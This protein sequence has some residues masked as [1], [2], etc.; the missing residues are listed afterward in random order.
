MVQHT[1]VGLIVQV[2]EVFLPVRWKSGWVHRVTVVLRCDVALTSSQVESWNVVGTV[3]VLELDSLRTDCETKQLMTET[4]SK[5][6]DLGRFHQAG[7]VVDGLLAMGWVTRAIGDEYT[8]KVVSNLVDWVVVWEASDGG[9]TADDTAKD[10]LLHT[11]INQ[12]NVEITNIGADM[13]WSFGRDSL[14]QV[15]G[16]R[17]NVCLVLIGI[18][19]LTDSDTAQ[20][21]ALLSEECDNVPGV[22]T[23]D[24][25]HTLPGAPLRQTLNGGPVTVLGCVICNHN[26]RRLDVGRLEVSEQTVLVTGGGGNS[27]VANQWLCE[28]K[29]LSTV[30]GIGHGLWVSD[31]G[32]CEDGLSRDVPVGSERFSCVGFSILAP[33]GFAIDHL[34]ALLTLMVKVARS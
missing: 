10:V 34:F 3:T 31:K 9:T 27:I 26:T 20:R 33:L 14:D 25:W 11:A 30:G 8:I 7:K 13:E 32:G 2:G 4:N 16:F 17:I 19:L 15:N 18:I 23:A 28:D 6:W 29:N 5:D 12:S 22:N 24:G 1:L 21:R